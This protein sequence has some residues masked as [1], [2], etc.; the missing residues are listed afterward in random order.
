MRVRE[1]LKEHHKQVY[2]KLEGA[3]GRALLT[4]ANTMKQTHMV[5]SLP[6]LHLWLIQLIRR[7]EMLHASNVTQNLPYLLPTLWT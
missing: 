4:V 6:L 2:S 1:T 7:S 5:P 3:Q